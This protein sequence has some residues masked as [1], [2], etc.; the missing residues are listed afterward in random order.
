M[1]HFYDHLAAGSNVAAALRAAQ[2]EVRGNRR[3][4]HPFYWAGFAVVGDGTRV[5][6]PLLAESQPGVWFKALVGAALVAGLAGWTWRR[7]RR[8]GI[9]AQA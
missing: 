2:L 9:P 6:R 7:R 4:S 8:P 3:T 5:V 1:K